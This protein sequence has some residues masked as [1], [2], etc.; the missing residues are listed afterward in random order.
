[1][2]VKPIDFSCRLTV[3]SE[4]PVTQHRSEVKFCFFKVDLVSTSNYDKVTGKNF[5]CRKRVV[6]FFPSEVVELGV[7]C[8]V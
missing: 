5:A 1:M 6:G 8:L 3:V 4:A 7:L 2:H